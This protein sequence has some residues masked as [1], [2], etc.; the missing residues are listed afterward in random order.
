MHEQRPCGDRCAGQRR[1]STCKKG[2][3]DEVADVFHVYPGPAEPPD[4][5]NSQENLE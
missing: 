2:D 1:D 4:K 5:R 3:D